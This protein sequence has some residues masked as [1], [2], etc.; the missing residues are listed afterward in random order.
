M[1]TNLYQTFFTFY[2]TYKTQKRSFLTFNLRC[3][4]FPGLDWTFKNKKILK[5]LFQNMLFKLINFT[6][7]I[8]FCSTTSQIYGWLPYHRDKIVTL[9]WKLKLD[10]TLN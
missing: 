1:F 2:L 9:D 10:K 7:C 8:N 5:T 6:S 3:T 4:S